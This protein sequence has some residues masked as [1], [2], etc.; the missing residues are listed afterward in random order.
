MK[1]VLEYEDLID[2]LEKDVALS[3]KGAQHS[4]TPELSDKH[5]G[6]LNAL[7]ILSG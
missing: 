1:Q 7:M 2:G 4:M 3:G 6:L 5:A